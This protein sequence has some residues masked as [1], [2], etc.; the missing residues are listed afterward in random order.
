M[1]DQT[2]LRN[3][4][5]DYQIWG[6][7]QIDPEAIAQMDQAM[8]LPVSVAGALMPDA[9][10][11]YGIPIGGV[12]ATDGVVIPY[13][14]G[15]D[16]ACRMRLSV[17]QDSPNV[18]GQR[19]EQFK[20]ALMEQTRFGVGRKG[21]EWDPR[22]QVDHDVL[23]DPDWQAT[24]YL[25]SLKDTAFRQLGTSGGGNHFANWGALTLEKDDDHEKGP[26]SPKRFLLVCLMFFSNF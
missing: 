1:T 7:E 3:E 16:I 21:G 5:L 23:D 17:F 12:L 14:V 13:A 8:R 24:K 10:I 18:I 15:V 9:H 25:A 11:G 6:Q 26:E 2:K 4:P 22:E 19:V 20:K